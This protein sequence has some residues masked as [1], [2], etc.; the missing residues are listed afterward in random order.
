MRYHHLPY[1]V[2]LLLVWEF[3][4]IESFLFSPSRSSQT[5]NLDLCSVVT[6]A[7]QKLSSE[8]FLLFTAASVLQALGLFSVTR[9]YE[10][11][12]SYLELPGIAVLPCLSPSSSKILFPLEWSAV[13]YIK[14][15]DAYITIIWLRFCGTLHINGLN[16][17]VIYLKK[18]IIEVSGSF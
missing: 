9:C 7:L 10:R 14:S 4:Q 15:S 12:F 3:V 2:L 18:K 11:L 6:V 13:L 17:F 8:T 16:L 1:P 5:L